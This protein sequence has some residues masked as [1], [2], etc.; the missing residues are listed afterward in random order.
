ML[1]A[2]FFMLVVAVLTGHYFLVERPRRLA[3]ETSA[4]AL[5]IPLRDL[6]NRVPGG[7]FLQPTFTWSRIHP[8]GALEVGVHPMLLSL[9][10]PECELETRSTGTHVDPG[11]PL[12]TVSSE[13]R[14]LVVRSPVAGTVSMANASPA[15]P[16]GWQ[17]RADRTCLIQPDRLAASVPTWMLGQ[18]AVDWSQTQYGRIRDHLLE[19]S[20]DP[21]TGLAL[22]DGGELPVGALK[23]LDPA[24]WADF[25]ARFLAG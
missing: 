11:D 15:D 8:D 23:Q 14:R 21:R 1:A 9:V 10:G 12:I 6:V 25:E 3:L 4:A 2:V 20:A 5:P 22:A 18:A 24:G 17:G 13:E 16:T 19:S 7:L